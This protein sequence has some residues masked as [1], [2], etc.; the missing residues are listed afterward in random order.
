[1][2][3]LHVFW[4]M[5]C[6]AKSLPIELIELSKEAAKKKNDDAQPDL[7]DSSL[8]FSEDQDDE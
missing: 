4:V 7:E 2:G 1:M 6:Y 3:Q 8:I 5:F